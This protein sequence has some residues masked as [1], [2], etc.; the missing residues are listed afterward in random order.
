MYDNV[1]IHY[2]DSKHRIDLFTALFWVIVLEWKKR[3]NEPSAFDYAMLAKTYQKLPYLKNNWRRALYYALKSVRKDKNYPYS[4]YIVASCYYMLD[5]YEKAYIYAKKSIELGGDEYYL[6][7]F[8]LITSSEGLGYWVEIFEYGYKYTHLKYDSPIYYFWYLMIN[9]YIKDKPHSNIFWK[10]LKSCL[11]YKKIPSFDEL[12]N[13]RRSFVAQKI[14]GEEYIFNRALSDQCY[15]VAMHIANK[16]LL[17]KKTAKWYMNKAQCCFYLGKNTKSLYYIDKAEELELNSKDFDYD[18]WR[19]LN[20]SILDNFQNALHYINKSILKEPA[21]YKYMNKASS[22]IGLEQY[23]EAIEVYNKV[24]SD[25]GQDCFTAF[26]WFNFAKSYFFIEDYTKSLTAINQCL[27]LQQDGCIYY[28][29][30]IILE[31][32]G[33]FDEAQIWFNKSEEPDEE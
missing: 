23:N 15:K 19:A 6:A 5:K 1:N 9:V 3:K 20:Y 32:L 22:L 24:K 27:L 4:Y 14:Y 21:F 16:E 29:K 26:D 13:I 31:Q 30:G 28:L 25:F 7:F 11:K 10:Y 8:Q 33:K 2:K 18:F 12:L 17:K